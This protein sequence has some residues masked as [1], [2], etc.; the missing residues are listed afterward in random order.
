[1]GKEGA[2]MGKEGAWMGKEGA[3]MGKEGVGMGREGV[4]M[5]RDACVVGTTWTG[6]VGSLGTESRTQSGNC[7][8]D[9]FEKNFTGNFAENSESLFA[10]DQSKTPHGNR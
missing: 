9:T 6:T 2:W 8:Q 4:L 10:F 1:M 3:W 7:P 5:G